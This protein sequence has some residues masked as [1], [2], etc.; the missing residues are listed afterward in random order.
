MGLD[1]KLEEHGKWPL[2]RNNKRHH[3][4]ASLSSEEI[5]RRTTVF[6]WSIEIIAVPHGKTTSFGQGR[7]EKKVRGGVTGPHPAFLISFIHP[8]QGRR[9]EINGANLTFGIRSLIADPRF[10]PSSLAN[11]RGLMQARWP[12]RQA[13]CRVAANPTRLF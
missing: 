2:L 5:S 1:R 12:P 8:G 13:A 10:Q 3:S 9:N 4:P 7:E 6:Y 11:W